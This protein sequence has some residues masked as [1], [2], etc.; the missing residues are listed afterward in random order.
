MYHSAGVM[1]R[2]GVVDGGNSMTGQSVMFEGS[3][4]D[5]IG[6]YVDDVEVINAQGCFGYYPQKGIYQTNSVCAHPVCASDNP[7]RGAQE[8]TNLWT[9]GANTTIT[10]DGYFA[11][12]IWVEDSYVYDVCDSDEMRINW[13]WEEGMYTNFGVTELE[14]FTPRTPPTA[15]LPWDAECWRP[16]ATCADFIQEWMGGDQSSRTSTND[17]NA[18][19]YEAL[20]GS[21]YGNKTWNDGLSSQDP[22]QR[23]L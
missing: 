6:G 9:A 15:N 1:V 2:R 4:A 14:E 3:S 13:E 20:Q 23:V 21:C 16:T 12:D 19:T 18:S 11:S 10:A 7:P 8:W 17:A 22:D 5:S